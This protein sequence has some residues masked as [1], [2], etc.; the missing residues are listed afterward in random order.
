VITD[1]DRQRLPTLPKLPD[2][3]ADAFVQMQL[4]ILRHRKAGWYDVSLDDVQ[5]ALRILE[6]MAAKH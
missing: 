1:S 3:L 5:Q 6:D 4:A 2:D